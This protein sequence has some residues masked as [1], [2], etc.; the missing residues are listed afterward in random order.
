MHK[1]RGFPARYPSSDYQFTLRRANKAGATTL[2]VRERFADRRNIDRAVD[3]AFLSALIEHFGTEPFPRG[4]LDAGRLS[5]LFEREVIPAQNPFDLQ[6][7]DALLQI[8]MD[9][10]MVSFPEIFER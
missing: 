8:D 2:K 10:A 4:N 1:H 6:C 7:Y 3:S 9:K 5:W